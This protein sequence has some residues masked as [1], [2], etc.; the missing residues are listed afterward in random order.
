MSKPNQPDWPVASELDERRFAVPGQITRSKSKVNQN[1]S[2]FHKRN[3]LYNELLEMPYGS[4][5][6]ER[7]ERHVK[8]MWP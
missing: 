2:T 7:L 4:E 1:T 6:L 3:G 5:R 8:Q